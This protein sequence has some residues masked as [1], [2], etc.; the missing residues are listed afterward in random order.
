MCFFFSF[1][2]E[3]I[4]IKKV[5]LIPTLYYLSPYISPLNYPEIPDNKK[6]SGQ[7]KSEQTNQVFVLKPSFVSR[8]SS[9]CRALIYKMR[10]L[11]YSLV[12]N[13][14][15]NCHGIL[16]PQDSETRMTKS[17]DGIWNFRL[18]PSLEPHLGFNQSW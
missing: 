8:R 3:H 17:L 18:Q 9:S 12:L 13:L 7:T 15:L 16:Y 6:K 2:H 10:L 14:V 5:K 11:V 4:K 1:V